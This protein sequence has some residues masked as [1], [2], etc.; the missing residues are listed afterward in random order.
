MKKKLWILMILMAA[1]AMLGFGTAAADGLEIVSY[2]NEVTVSPEPGTVGR[3]SWT[4]N[5]PVLKSQIVF[6]F[7]IFSDGSPLGTLKTRV[8]TELDP[9]RTEYGLTYST[10]EDVYKQ[11]PDGAQSHRWGVRCFYGSGSEDYVQKNFTMN[12]IPRKVTLDEGTVTVEPK[13]SGEISWS[14]NFDPKKI[15]LV[16]SW[17]TPDDGYL[18]PEDYDYKTVKELPGYQTSCQLSFSE[19]EKAMDVPGNARDRRWEIR[20]YYGSGSKDYARAVVDMDISSYRISGIAKFFTIDPESS[21]PIEWTANFDP[22]KIQIG[23]EYYIPGSGRI[24]DFGEYKFVP[25]AS[26]KSGAMNRYDLSYAEAETPLN[27]PSAKWKDRWWIV[28]AFYGSGKN[29]YTADSF[30]VDL[31]PRTLTCDSEYY[32]IGEGGSAVIRWTANYTATRFELIYD[33]WDGNPDHDSV[34]HVVETWPANATQGHLSYERMQ[35]VIADN[36]NFYPYLEGWYLRGYYGS[37]EDDYSAD[38]I[39]PYS[40]YFTQQP[41]GGFTGAEN[42]ITVSFSTNF[43]PVTIGLAH[44]N[45]K[46]ELLNGAEYENPVN[47]FMSV[48]DTEG[49]DRQVEIEMKP[50][51]GSAWLVAAA[52]YSES[53]A[54]LSQ[55]FQVAQR[56]FT[57]EPRSGNVNRYAD[58]GT[59]Q[60]RVT[61]ATCFPPVR[62]IIFRTDENGTPVEGEDAWQQ[63]LDPGATE[64]TISMPTDAGSVRSFR[65]RAFYGENDREYIDSRVFHVT[66]PAILSWDHEILLTEGEDAV[67]R[68]ETTVTPYKVEIYRHPDTGDTPEVDPIGNYTLAD[69]IEPESR[70][71]E[72]TIP[73]AS[74]MDQDYVYRIMTYFDDGVSRSKLATARP[75]RV[76]HPGVRIR[77][78]LGEGRE[79]FNLWT[80][81]FVPMTPIRTATGQLTVPECRILPPDDMMFDHWLLTY[82]DPSVGAETTCVPGE[83]ITAAGD[84]TLTPVWVNRVYTW[85]GAEHGYDIP[86]TIPYRNE[87]VSFFVSS[88]IAPYIP[89]D[90]VKYDLSPEGVMTAKGSPNL[91]IAWY[92]KSGSSWFE[93]DDSQLT[94]LPAEEEAVWGSAYY[95]AQGPAAPGEYKVVFSYMGAEVLEKAFTITD[96]DQFGV[97]R[98]FMQENLN[99]H[100]D[101]LPVMFDPTDAKQFY[102]LDE[103]GGGVSWSDLESDGFV[104]Y[105]WQVGTKKGDE[106]FYNDLESAPVYGGKY[107]LVIQEQGSGGWMDAAYFP[108]DIEGTAVICGD[109]TGWE[110]TTMTLNPATGLYEYRAELSPEMNPMGV[111]EFYF[112]IDDQDYGGFSDERILYDEG[113]AWLMEAPDYSNFFLAPS[114]TAEFTFV[115]DTASE[116][117]TVTNDKK[118][119][120][121]FLMG[122]LGDYPIRMVDP[123]SDEMPG[124]EGVMDKPI[125]P[126]IFPGG[127]TLWAGG[128][129]SEG[130]TLPFWIGNRGQT[131]GTAS[132][133]LDTVMDTE[134]SIRSSITSGGKEFIGYDFYFCPETHQLMIKIHRFPHELY[135]M[136]WNPE[137]RTPMTETENYYEYTQD[138]SLFTINPNSALHDT[139]DGLRVY[140]G[141]TL[142]I[143]PPEFDGYRVSSWMPCTVDTRWSDVGDR[144]ELY[145]PYDRPVVGSSNTLVYPVENL[146][147]NEPIYLTAV[148]TPGSVA[149]VTVTFDSRG[150]T[151]V[152][153]VTVSSG[154]SV[155][156]PE[157]PE[158]TGEAF[159]GWYTDAACTAEAK[160]DFLTPVTGDLTLFAGWEIPEFNGIL[161]LPAGLTEI[162]VDAFVGTAAEAVVIPE[163][164]VTIE[165]NP[166]ASGSV[167]YIFGFG[168]AAKTMSETYDYRWVLIDADWLAMH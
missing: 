74:V 42:R 114:G 163:S 72:Y 31:T 157:A 29:D 73:W 168:G 2:T 52:W 6:E 44:V 123:R 15:R 119:N 90:M 134:A 103:K 9:T 156:K 39:V 58:D 49:L 45:E 110:E 82:D 139:D 130:E 128:C 37:G 46:G 17:Y 21:A 18:I 125:D 47:Y 143:T 155:P 129:V 88:A 1:V 152:P 142:I 154:N 14:T 28:R 30:R 53:Q 77:F 89:S 133:S 36:P 4:T 136:T 64:Y 81:E 108:F 120:G 65:I 85:V 84:A 54:V 55:P 57:T 48:G 138:F 19:A 86:E 69:T 104:R 70:I 116:S 151:L 101:G 59:P 127:T 56:S 124:S 41:A 10:V 109:V 97:Y 106:I 32:M 80:R 164:V 145:N 94:V 25:V 26:L 150:G 122:F 111:L 137:T 91:T 7:L 148:Y 67:L 43:T 50:D 126:Y 22:V 144:Y 131:R 117:I 61:W 68:F 100:Y 33:T 63:E 93:Y 24:L 76:Y 23:Y 141:D 96:A 135:L 60:Y 51:Y 167:R 3:V 8:I 12:M 62:Q 79:S 66:R 16:Y 75:I 5:E 99:K 35:E 115:L 161:K 78:A 165:G 105:I 98:Y 158:K 112:I 102:I 27:D 149:P 83:Q 153:T 20:A 107:R 87:R 166:F 121:A 162:G 140:D 92:E 95:Y 132:V 113:T 11:T 160:F 159:T 147:G 34:A 40:S 118:L 38:W 146:I 71:G 13:V